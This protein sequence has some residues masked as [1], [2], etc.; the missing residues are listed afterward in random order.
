MKKKFGTFIAIPEGELL[1][2][3]RQ[4]TYN[5]ILGWVRATIVAEEMHAMRMLRTVICGLSSYTV[6]FHIVS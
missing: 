4:R 2:Q 6:F 3:D 5:V 1:K